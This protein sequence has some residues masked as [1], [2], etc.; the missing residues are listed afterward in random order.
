MD[1]AGG[2]RC[3]GA[4]LDGPGAA[5]FFAV[6]Q[7]ADKP[8]QLV[9]G[10]DQLVQTRGLNA[11]LLQEGDFLLLRGACDVLLGLGAD[12]DGLGVFL[13]GAGFDQR[14]IGVLVQTAQQIVLAHVAGVDDRLGRKQ[15]QLLA[16]S[17][18][19]VVALVKIKAAGGLAAL[20]PGSQFGKPGGLGGGSL[21]AGLGSLLLATQTVAD[22]LQIR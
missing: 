13:L 6:G 5:F 10:F 20:Q 16:H 3:L 11:H 14:Q 9:A 19:R 12:G 1:L 2:L 22:N 4:A 15:T 8:Q 17:L 18:L 7:K 21:V